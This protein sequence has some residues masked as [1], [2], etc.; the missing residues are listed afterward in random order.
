MIWKWYSSFLST[1]IHFSWHSFRFEE[2]IW[3]TNNII[4]NHSTD[5]KFFDN[6]YSLLC[7][8]VRRSTTST[9]P[10]VWFGF[11]LVQ[12][13]STDFGLLFYINLL[14][15]QR[16]N[17][18]WTPGFHRQLYSPTSCRKIPRA[19]KHV[20]LPDKYEISSQE[21]VNNETFMMAKDSKKSW[22]TLS[23]FKVSLLQMKNPVEVLLVLHYYVHEWIFSPE[24][25]IPARDNQKD[26]CASLISCSVRSKL[27]HDEDT[28]A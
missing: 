4:F 16:P 14:R 17:W 26:N 13:F 27:L 1:A 3:T 2:I 28:L 25:S 22:T 15:P 20:I 24:V 8:M 21:A 23:P 11:T 9:P 7:T 5:A 10:L 12:L 19:V 18:R 6:L